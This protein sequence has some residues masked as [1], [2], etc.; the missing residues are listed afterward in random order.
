MNV[1]AYI[2]RSLPYIKKWFF[3]FLM[4]IPTWVVIEQFWMA[5]NANILFAVNYPYPFFIWP[6][7][8]V[9]DNL[10]LIIHEGGHTIFGFFGWRFLGILGGTLMQL[11]IP[12]L[13][14]LSAWYKK[15]IT[16]AQFSLFWLG[17]SWMD[18]AAYCYD[19]MF[20]NLPLIGNLPK[21]AHD[22]HNMLIDLNLINHYKTIAWIMFSI[23]FLILALGLLWPLFKK[24]ELEYVNL[25]DELEK[26]GLD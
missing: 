18:S 2:D 25:S 6:L 9:L 20:R 4:F 24:E 23:G 15:Q 11:L 19:A 21:S 13:I 10:T 26:S 12:F 7:M 5:L 16:L 17:F 22:F 14:F 1:E 3:S 8:F